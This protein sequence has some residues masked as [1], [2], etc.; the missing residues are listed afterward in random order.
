MLYTIQSLTKEEEE[1]LTRATDLCE[2]KNVQIIFN[3]SL[4]LLYLII[5]F[6]IILQL[7]LITEQDNIDGPIPQ[8]NVDNGKGRSKMQSQYMDVT[9]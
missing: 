1:I 7:S 6:V 3:Y 4:I 8:F 5:Q 2:E 9:G